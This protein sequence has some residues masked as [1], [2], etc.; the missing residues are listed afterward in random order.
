MA[1]SLRN[2]CLTAVTLIDSAVAG[3]KASELSES[4][5]ESKLIV[6]ACMRISVI[7]LMLVALAGCAP[8]S[9]KEAAQ[10]REAAFRSAIDSQRKCDANAAS[11]HP[12][13][14]R[15][16]YCSAGPSLP[17]ECEAPGTD[18]DPVCRQWV[19]DRGSCTGGG[20]PPKPPECETPHTQNLPQ[21]RQWAA[22]QGM[23]AGIPPWMA[24][25]L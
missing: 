13:F 10:K 6:E 1:R 8:M 2:N 7:G 9:A 23:C 16:I 3:A 24:G 11:G 4:S 22:D 20:P 25:I 21:C 15:T 5:E 18:D 12:S 19:L 14:W 17:A